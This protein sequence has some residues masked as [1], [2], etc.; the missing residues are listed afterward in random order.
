[1]D[2]PDKQRVLAGGFI[3][4]SADLDGC[5]VPGRIELEIYRPHVSWAYSKCHILLTST[6]RL[7]APFLKAQPEVLLP[8]I[9]DRRSHEITLNPL[10][11][12]ATHAGQCPHLECCG[13][14]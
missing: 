10:L 3:N 2:P 7:F 12:A 13:A 9:D 8:A 14:N 5:T 1:M 11:V 4:N 6:D